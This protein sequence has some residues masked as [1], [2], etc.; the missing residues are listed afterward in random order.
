MIY[1]K[2]NKKPVLKHRIKLSKKKL[3]VVVQISSVESN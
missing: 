1:F 2:Y 3:K